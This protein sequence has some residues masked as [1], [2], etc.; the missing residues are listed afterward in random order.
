VFEEVFKKF[1][2]KNNGIKAMGV[3][4]KDGLELEKTYFSDAPDVDLE[5][6]GAELADIISKLDSTKLSPEM[7]FL[8]LNFHNYYLRIF[9][10]TE[11]YFLMVLTEHDVIDGKLQFYLNLYKDSIVASL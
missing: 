10:L 9:S 8:K 7:Y 2:E 1:H 6:S 5:F 3:W 11:D 4:G